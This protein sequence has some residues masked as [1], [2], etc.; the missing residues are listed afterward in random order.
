MDE[1]K[2]RNPEVLERAQTL[3]T[4]LHN[5]Y[6]DQRP[7][8]EAATFPDKWKRWGYKKYLEAS[9]VTVQGP[10]HYV[11]QPY[12]NGIPKEE[13][14]IDE[15]NVVNA[16]SQLK[17]L[18][19]DPAADDDVA[20]YQLRCLIHYVG[21]IHQPLHATTMYSEDF[22]NGD[23]GGNSFKLE[24]HGEIKELHALWDSVVQA[25]PTD[26]KQPL[27]QDGLDSV[28][29]ASKDIRDTFPR[30]RLFLTSQDPKDWAKESYE[31]STSFVYQNIEEGSWPDA[32]YLHIGQMLAKERLAYGGY[33]LADTLM[34][35]WGSKEEE[36]PL[37]LW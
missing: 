4:A 13:I 2:Q 16:I 23:R 27:N 20:S 1:L 22:P 37:F 11:D 31:A 24:R 5:K 35:L 10:W 28:E 25:Y 36:E 21:D 12:F 32:Q 6:E 18:L 29:A 19:A 34:D 7:F 9:P 3:L 33:R 26:W 17:T 15:T 30:G 14:D 8:V